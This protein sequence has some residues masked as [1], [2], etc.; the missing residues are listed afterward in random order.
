MEKERLESAGRPPR[1]PFGELLGRPVKRPGGSKLPRARIARSQRPGLQQRSAPV[2]GEGRRA[3]RAQMDAL[4]G[5]RLEAGA[6]ASAD[7]TGRLEERGRALLAQAIRRDL[8]R[9]ESRR[10]EA[11][12]TPPSL[13]RAVADRPAPTVEPGAHASEGMTAAGKP[14]GPPGAEA[15]ERALELVEQVQMFLRSGRPALSLTLRG[16]MAGRV[17]VQRVGAGKVALRFESRR[18]PGASELATM[19]AELQRRGL[20][21]Q[22]MDVAS[23]TWRGD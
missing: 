5:A 15:A 10:G 8:M 18:R 4:V 21:V 2:A 6:Q 1:K 3:A 20:T 23:L 7:A 9:P 14:S 22:S 19:R 11:V 16:A 12:S 17:E 13:E